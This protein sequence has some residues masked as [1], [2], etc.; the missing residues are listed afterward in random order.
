MK[1][2]L[3]L[4]TVFTLV[5]TSCNPLEDINTEIDAITTNTI[6]GDVV[7]TLT[8]EDYESLD[9]SKAYFDD[10]DIAKSMIPAFLSNK[11]P[12]WGNKS[13]AFI[14]Y[15]LK[16]GTDLEVV[17]DYTSASNY[18]V[19]NSD[20]PSAADNA[21]GFY[22]S[23]KASNF[24][25]SILANNIANPTKG[26]VSLVKYSQYVG[27]TVNGI[28]EIFSEDFAGAG[29]LLAFEAISV[30]GDQVWQGTTYGAKITGYVSG[31]GNFANEDWLVSQKIDLTSFS[32]A[33]FQVNQILNYGSPSSV[34]VQISSNYTG[35]VTTATWD[36][37]N[38]TT[39]PDGKSW[40]PVLSEEFNLSA[41][42]GKKVNIAFKYTSTDSSAG[43]YEVVKATIKAPG[44][45]GQSETKEVY[46]SFD[47]SDWK[48]SQKVYYLT[49]ADYDS[50]GQSSGQPG[51]YNNFDSSLNPNNY[52]PTLLNTKYTYAQEGDNLLVFFK[53]YSG[54]TSVRGNQFTFTNGVW[55]AHQTQLQFGHDGT[56]WVPDNT[57]KYTL[58][59]KDD[60]AYMAS[61]LTGA[62]YA[63]FLA[64]LANYGDFDY[65]WT[66][67]QIYFALALFLDH[68]DPNAAEDQKYTLTYV[69]YDNG[70]N[71][72]QTSFIKK[73]G[74]WVL[75]D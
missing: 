55:L 75:N 27:E 6:V 44:V 9:L 22:E 73:G 58:V 46:Y 1:K 12:V 42:D 24:I 38:F 53:Y 70:E 23:E 45:T 66:K 57:I 13:S 43:T 30:V 60:Y 14:S 29:T 37:I 62:E 54:G 34:S 50:M 72:Y 49:S 32:N 28:T 64:N 68:L 25:P 5:F 48:L 52:I 63:G 67:T 61:Q 35:D 10:N 39:V 11:Y 17:T 69:I 47:G 51:K 4:L 2:I 36:V 74:V 59:R 18:S 31:S 21:T 7:Y 40:T 8:A 3:L 56:K 71:D 33:K 15:E 19:S 20:Y 65:N 41:Y 16:N 26:Q